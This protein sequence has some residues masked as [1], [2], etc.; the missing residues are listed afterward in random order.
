MWGLYTVS[1][2]RRAAFC[3]LQGLQGRVGAR[4]EVNWSTCWTCRPDLQNLRGLVHLRGAVLL[5][6][7]QIGRGVRR[8]A[9]VYHSRRY[10]HFVLFWTLDNIPSADR[11]GRQ[12]GFEILSL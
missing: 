5:A 9:A 12:P 6:R 11:M 4:I 3:F 10:V 7:C 2:A 1:C 8:G